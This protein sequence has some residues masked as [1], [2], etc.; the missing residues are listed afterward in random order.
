[1]LRLPVHN[2]P[3]QLPHLSQLNHHLLL[4]SLP[5]PLL[6][7]QP[8]MQVLSLL[9]SLMRILLTLWESLESQESYA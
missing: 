3:T 9:V 5:Q 6:Q 7:H 4:N 8:K 2:Q 1:M